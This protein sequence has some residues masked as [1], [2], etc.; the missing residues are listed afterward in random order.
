MKVLVCGKGGSGKS[1]IAAL[2]AK[3]FEA[4]GYRVLAID[5]D[6][7]NFGLSSMLGIAPKKELMEALG[8][9]QALV[10]KMWAKRSAGEK[11]D[12][13]A[14]SWG[15]DDIPADCISKKGNMNLLLIGKVKHFGEGCA[16]P[17]GGLLRDFLT[18]LRLGNNEIAIIDAEAGV[19]HF[20]RGV[21]GGVDSI[22][23][24]LDPSYESILLS[25]KLLAMAT[26]GSKKV[27]FIL[28][29]VDGA[30]ASKILEKVKGEVLGSVPFIKEIQ[31]KCLEGEPLDLPVDGIGQ[32]TEFLMR[33]NGGAS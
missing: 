7:S 3:D 27:Y 2:L 21:E 4:K 18:H 20:G 17:M 6:E 14:G 25:E 10:D 32:I 31:Q 26:E 29:K 33:S 1:T 13:I 30:I 9:K 28:N 19:E 11:V 22:L 12:I 5:A 24:V 15:I 8:G 16:C 23:M